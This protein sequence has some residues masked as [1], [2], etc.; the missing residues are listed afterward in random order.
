M[1]CACSEGDRD[2]SGRRAECCVCVEGGERGVSWDLMVVHCLGG[3]LV[4]ISATPE[5]LG[6]QH[7]GPPLPSFTFR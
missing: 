5:A 4:T 7:R 1:R 6:R 3:G 2:S